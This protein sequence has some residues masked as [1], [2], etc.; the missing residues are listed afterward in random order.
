MRA[1]APSDWAETERRAFLAGRLFER[2]RL[3][4]ELSVW[5]A[6]WLPPPRT[7]A[8]R[9]YRAEMDAMAALVAVRPP[10]GPG[11]EWPDCVTTRPP[12]C[13]HPRARA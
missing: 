8:A 4:D 13:P 7:T 11:D 3:A 9:R 12:D 6:P 2:Q 5:H 10:A 1:G